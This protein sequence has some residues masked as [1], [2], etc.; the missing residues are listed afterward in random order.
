MNPL[1][2]D[3]ACVAAGVFLGACAIAWALSGCGMQRKEE[4]LL[5]SKPVP[6][7]R[8]A[9]GQVAFMHACYQCHPGGAAGLGPALNNKPLPAAAI[10][11]QVRLGA[12][13][14]PSFPKERLSDEELDG[15]VEY[16]QWL[17][18]VP[19]QHS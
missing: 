15:I 9:A 10:R 12:G 1:R 2:I 8:V 17:R 18:H 5:G 14:M 6:Q 7:G 11:T 16:V 3:R 13:A 19:P 4:P